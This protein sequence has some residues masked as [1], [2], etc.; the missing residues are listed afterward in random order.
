MH[1]F[2]VSLALTHYESGPNNEAPIP[3]VE[4]ESKHR[5]FGENDVLIESKC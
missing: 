2:S 4:I 3:I 5:S 1:I